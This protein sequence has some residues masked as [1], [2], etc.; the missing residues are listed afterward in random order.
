ML[1]YHFPKH[2][3]LVTGVSETGKTTHWMKLLT[4][5]GWK[6]LFVF[7]PDREVAIKCG[8]KVATNLREIVHQ[9]ATTRIVCFDSSSMFPGCPEEGFAF[10]TRWVMTIARKVKGPIHFGCDEIWKVTETGRG[11]IPPAFKEM[12]NEGRR[13]EI[14]GFFI[15]QAVN[16]VHDK[17][18]TQLTYLY[19]FRHNEPN[20]LDWLQARGFDPDEILALPPKGVYLCRNIGLGTITKGGKFLGTQPA[21]KADR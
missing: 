13:F 5:G 14:R 6:W 20:C 4:S 7:D 8:F 11:G 1:N 15:A 2:F 16:E 21:T 12:M 10:F 3:V 9:A 19:T 17:I 18:R